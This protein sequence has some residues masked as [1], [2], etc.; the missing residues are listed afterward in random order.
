M[1]AAYRL[2]P[3][4]PRWDGA[5]RGF[6]AVVAAHLALSTAG[7]RNTWGGCTSS[8][9]KVGNRLAGRPQP[10]R[11]LE[12]HEAA[13]G[14]AQQA[15]RAAGADH[16]ERRPTVVSPSTAPFVHGGS[17]VEPASTVRPTGMRCLPS[18]TTAHRPA[19]DGPVAWCSRN[20][21][22]GRLR[23][24]GNPETAPSARGRRR[25][26]RP[27]LEVSARDR[28]HHR[29]DRCEDVAE[30]VEPGRS[31]RSAR[32]AG[33]SS[34]GPACLSDPGHG[35]GSGGGIS[36]TDASGS[37]ASRPPGTAGVLRGRH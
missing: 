32:L 8:S 1:R 6:L 25:L 5:V 30:V 10:L 17:S 2:A 24:S 19:R 29:L 23:G 12:R 7:V 3:D 4:S 16:A 36:G 18:A 14:A 33:A 28:H 15:V 13:E 37:K 21:R 26:E 20:P 35:E 11:H 22:A 34:T 9:P 27:A 31:P